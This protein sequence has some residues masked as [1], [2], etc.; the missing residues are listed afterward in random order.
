MELQAVGVWSRELAEQGEVGRDLDHAAEIEQLGYGSI[1]VP[2]RI[3]GDTLVAVE[4]VLAATTSIPVVTGIL[5]I[6][7][8]DPAEVADTFHRLDE[9]FPGRFHL[10]VGISHAPVVTRRSD[11]QWDNRPLA[12]LA[13]YLDELDATATPVPHD[14][15]LVAALGPRAMR[16]AR[17]RSAG[18]HP[19]F[20]PVAHTAAARE[21]MGPD[22]IVAAEATVLVETDPDRARA[23]AR[24]FMALYL[25]LPNYTNNL[26]R[27]GFT[28]AD[29]TDGGSDRLVDAIVGWGD[30]DAVAA[31]VREHLDAGADHVCIQVIGDPARRLDDWRR[32]APVLLA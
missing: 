20:T 24:E 5:N 21:A 17:D 12:K 25:G 3:S 8:H 15:M 28:D 22:G 27:H 7:V 9:T 23:A 16:L 11:R 2:G 26:L 29:L 19:Y 30:E 32:L 31:R 1:F 4:N 13:S 6:W 10:G 18:T 14:R